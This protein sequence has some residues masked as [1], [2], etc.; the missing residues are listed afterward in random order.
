LLDWGFCFLQRNQNPVR[1]FV[2]EFPHLHAEISEFLRSESISDLIKSPNDVSIDDK[3][4]ETPHQPNQPSNDLK[5]ALAQSAVESVLGTP[6]SETI[7]TAIEFTEISQQIREL[8]ERIKQLDQL[9]TPLV[10]KLRAGG[11]KWATIAKYAD[12]NQGSA[13]RKWD[14]TVQ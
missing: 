1:K 3:S 2:V 9:R 7:E 12:M 5:R 10:E 6:S 4:M 8:Q 14:P 11:T 13:Q